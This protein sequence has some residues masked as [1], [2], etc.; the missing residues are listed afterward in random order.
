M[1]KRE[2]DYSSG[3]T[4]I[5]MRALV[6]AS[7]AIASPAFGAEIAAPNVATLPSPTV[8]AP[9]MLNSTLTMICALCFC[10][11]VFAIGVRYMPRFMGVPKSGRPRR[12]EVREKLALS[13]KAALF[14]VAI[15]NREY[16]VASGSDSVSVTATHSITTPLFAESLDEIYEEPGE[17]HA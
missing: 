7:V 2:L 17:L 12:I 3:A 6:L 14:L 10:L 8:G 16:L 11:G 4:L 9:T 1:R 15:D 5:V 13:P